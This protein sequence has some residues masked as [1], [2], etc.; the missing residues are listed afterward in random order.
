MGRAWSRATHI[1]RRSS[2]S[3]W[4]KRSRRARYS[5]RLEARDIP[6]VGHTCISKY[7]SAMTIT[8]TASVKTRSFARCLASSAKG[9]GVSVEIAPCAEDL[10]ARAT[11]EDGC[12]ATV[13]AALTGPH[14]RDSLGNT[15]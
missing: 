2:H 1:S 14:N 7:G 13:A 6:R 3:S 11:H 9:L 4:E 10:F 8:G 5:V 12:A 15:E